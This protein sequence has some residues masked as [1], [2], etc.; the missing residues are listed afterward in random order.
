MVNWKADAAKDQDTNRSD[1]SFQS[2]HDSYTRDSG[3]GD[4]VISETENISANCE[5]VY[6]KTA[7]SSN[8]ALR[9]APRNSPG[10]T[11]RKPTFSTFMGDSDAES[12]QYVEYTHSISV[13]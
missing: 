5:K 11:D 13:K 12:V 9:N 4:S 2:N 8:F 10:V 7:V 6:L 1:R 3:A